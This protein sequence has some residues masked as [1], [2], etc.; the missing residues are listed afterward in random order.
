[1]N[2]L[3][4]KIKYLDKDKTGFDQQTNAIFLNDIIEEISADPDNY[5]KFQSSIPNLYKKVMDELIDAPVDIKPILLNSVIKN[6]GI[7][8][9]LGKD[10][11]VMFPIFEEYLQTKS[12]S[13]IF[14]ELNELYGHAID[15][16]TKKVDVDFLL[17]LAKENF[18]SPEKSESILGKLVNNS[19]FAPKIP[20]VM[21]SVIAFNELSQIGDYDLSKNQ[22]E[23]MTSLLEKIENSRSLNTDL[24]KEIEEAVKQYSKYTF[25]N[26]KTTED[27]LH[28]VYEEQKAE[29][30]GATISSHPID[31][32]IKEVVKDKKLENEEVPFP[33]ERIEWEQRYQDYLKSIGNVKVMSSMDK[34]SK[35]FADHGFAP[36]TSHLFGDSIVVMDKY[37]DPVKTMWNVSSLT[38]TMRLGKDVNYHDPEMAAQTFAIAALNARR[39]GWT[40]IYLNHPGPDTEAKHFIEESVKAMVEIGNYE[41]DQIRVPHRYAHVL[42]QMR[43]AYATIAADVL[44]PEEYQTLKDLKVDI[45]NDMSDEPVDRSIT[46]KLREKNEQSQEKD[47]FVHSDFDSDDMRNFAETN[48][49]DIP[50]FTEEEADRYSDVRLS[51]FD[52]DIPDEFKE[53][54]DKENKNDNKPRSTRLSFRN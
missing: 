18:T 7:N 27:K 35:K 30:I 17:E 51:E 14:S 37:G 28:A 11:S 39:K 54:K 5:K 23:L 22:K 40:S 8:N 15:D 29:D 21:G 47:D 53:D 36:A 38:G 1:M 4:D 6:V 43:N 13:I 9:Q 3:E 42:E 19:N 10:N 32:P 20:D 46:E 12:D 45:G 44:N 48:D 25:N 50:Q 41:F 2:T 16:K 34:F 49:E 52:V 24:D 33:I 26:Y 31:T